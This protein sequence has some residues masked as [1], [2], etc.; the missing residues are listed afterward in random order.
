VQDLDGKSDIPTD[1]EMLLF[2]QTESEEDI[3]SYYE[4]N[5]SGESTKPKNLSLIY[6]GFY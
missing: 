4:F 2:S 6:D 5:E 1:E 3:I